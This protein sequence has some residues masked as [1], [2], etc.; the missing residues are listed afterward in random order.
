[1]SKKKANIQDDLHAL[2][3]KYDMQDFICVYQRKDA[4]PLNVEFNCE[5]NYMIKSARAII[6][7]Y[8]THG[9]DS[10]VPEPSRIILQ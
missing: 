8:H 4:H 1:M 2:F 6:D 7:V 10:E 5:L 9:K 3:E